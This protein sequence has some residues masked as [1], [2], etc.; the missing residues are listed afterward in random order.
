MKIAILS[1]HTP[2]LFWFRIDMMQE[3]LNLKHEVIAVGNEEED[4]WKA[5]FEA[6]GIKYRKAEIQR[7]GTNPF[8]DLKTLRSLKKIIKEEKVDKI[9]TYQ[10]KTVIYG[11]IAA[12]KIETYPLIAGVGSMFL[13][14][15]L[16]AKIIRWILKIEYKIALKRAQKVFFQN[17]DDV[18][19]FVEKKIVDKNKIVMLHGSGVN[20]QK[21]EPQPLPEKIAF[22]C[23]SRLIKDKGIYEY[24]Q[25][26][27]IVKKR[28]PNVRFLLVGPFDSNPSALKD[29]ELKPYIAS[30]T[31]EYFGEQL[32]VRPY[33][34]QCSV[35]VLPSYREGTPKT[36]LEAMASFKAI[37]TTNAPGC[38]ETV[39]DNK[40][41]FLVPIK[42]VQVLAERMCE[43]INNPERIAE[44]AKE[45]RKL[46]E[47]KF[48]VKKVN[49]IILG[50]MNL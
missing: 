12:K 4:I 15:S 36:V 29:E 41:G 35:Y 8:R 19:I 26:A 21:F 1:S 33:L 27:E 37:I 28:Y 22:L 20:L 31:I 24:L 2:S 25:A 39:E 49:K 32:D 45:G 10:A 30:G 46:V 50:A 44:M 40:N 47:E 23:I 34:A 18:K 13:S 17:Q 43:L 7:N 38:R 11:G 9:F 16:K 6:L 42:N 5:K 48:D 14:H 3:F